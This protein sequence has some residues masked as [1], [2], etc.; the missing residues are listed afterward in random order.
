MDY[1]H[2]IH[3]TRRAAAKERGTNGLQWGGTAEAPCFAASRLKAAGR[4]APPPLRAAP[5]VLCGGRTQTGFHHLH[6][7][8]TLPHGLRLKQAAARSTQWR[9]S[10]A[11]H[12]LSAHLCSCVSSAST[13]PAHPAEPSSRYTPGRWPNGRW[14][15][16]TADAAMVGLPE[17][18]PPPCF[19]I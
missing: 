10:A 12:D 8:L 3:C 2:H 18:D 7:L 13:Y 6:L 4:A 15:N 16:A 17:S 5:A 11:L 1:I 9:A 14:W 19:I